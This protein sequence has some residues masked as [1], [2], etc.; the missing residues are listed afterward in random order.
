MY[1]AGQFCL[2]LI[3]SHF[4]HLRN[5]I[6]T[7]SSGTGGAGIFGSFLYAALIEIGITPVNTMLI[8]LSVPLL[9]GATFWVLLR[10]PNT[11]PKC[12]SEPQFNQSPDDQESATDGSEA[13]M[14]LGDKIRYVPSLLKYVVPLLSVYLFEYFINQ[15]MV[16][17]ILSNHTQFTWKQIIT[18]TFIYCLQMEL[19][20]FKNIWLD[21][22][23]QYRWF[24]VCF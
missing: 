19:V 2:K 24:Q 16:S 4:C 11:I 22:K 15:G 8:M 9:E 17:V 12:D 18:V 14:S 1:V 20:Y 3:F 23:R 5:V 13:K 6:S 10:N 7:W 21:H